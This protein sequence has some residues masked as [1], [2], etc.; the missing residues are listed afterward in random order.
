MKSKDEK[1]AYF[2]DPECTKL[3]TN[4]HFPEPI[5]RG[6]EKISIVVYAKNV[7]KLIMSKLIFESNH[8]NLTVE[9]SD[10]KA[11]PLDVIQLKLT[12]APDD[13]CPE[14]VTTG[15]RVSGEGHGIN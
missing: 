3:L 6:R 1:F 5:V 9:A 15:F 10:N 7:S 2:E 4:I 12:F 8:K 11:Y 14:K 13:D